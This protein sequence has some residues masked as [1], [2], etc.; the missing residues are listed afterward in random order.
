M[1]S[2]KLRLL[3]HSEYTQ[4]VEY[5]SSSNDK[6][7][8]VAQESLDYVGYPELSQVGIRLQNDALVTVAKERSAF[9]TYL[10]AANEEDGLSSNVCHR[11]G[12]SNLC[13][14]DRN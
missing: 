5:N 12:S 8:S 2:I 10:T 3:Q 4:Q 6:A 9:S 14:T 11:K 13:I 1:K 7:K